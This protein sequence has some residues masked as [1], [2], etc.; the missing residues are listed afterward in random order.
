LEKDLSTLLGAK[1]RITLHGNG[2]M[3]TLRYKTLQE[4]EAILHRLQAQKSNLPP[5]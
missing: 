4:L 3:L 5:A 1:A 2:G